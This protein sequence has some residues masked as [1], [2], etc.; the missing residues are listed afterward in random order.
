MDFDCGLLFQ[1][2]RQ[3]RERGI[4]LHGNLARQQSQQLLV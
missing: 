3:F 1:V 4:G 2:R